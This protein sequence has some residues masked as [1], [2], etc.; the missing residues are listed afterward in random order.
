[1]LDIF[2]R[3]LIA[4]EVHERESGDHVAALIERACWR[5]QR[6]QQPLILHTDNGAPQTSYTLR[7]KLE[8]LGTRASHSRPGVSDDNAHIKAWFRTC[9][10]AASYPPHGFATIEQ[11]RHWVLGFVSWYN[12]QH[13]H[14]GL[15]F[16]TPEQRHDGSYQAVLEHR[17]EVYRRAREQHPLRW[18][19]HV[20]PWAVPD[21]VWLNPPSPS[22]VR[23]VA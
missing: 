4:C 8:S 15:A 12:D 23:M 20:R 1:M 22:E 10:Y 11:A 5:E 9:K 16:V 14:S 13:R 6:R 7:A 17:R 18:K 21:H 19:R 2:S 3:K